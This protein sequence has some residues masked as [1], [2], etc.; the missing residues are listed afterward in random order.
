MYNAT[1][2]YKYRIGIYIA[3]SVVSV[4]YLCVAHLT[5][6]V[7]IYSEIYALAFGQRSHNRPQEASQ[8]T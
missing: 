8:E 4:A 6:L 3:A 5:A 2:D 1:V 7:L